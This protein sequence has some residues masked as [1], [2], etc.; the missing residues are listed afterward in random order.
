MLVFVDDDR[1]PYNAVRAWWNDGSKGMKYRLPREH[2]FEQ[3]GLAK[4]AA[5]G[6]YKVGEG[7]LIYDASSPAA[8]TH[9]RDGADHLRSLVR[10]ACDAVKLDYRETNYLALRRGP[11]LIAAGLGESLE[12]APH[13]LHGHF[14]DLFDAKLPIVESVT[15]T[16]GTRHFLFD[17]DHSRSTKPAVLASACKVLGARPLPTA[18][19]ASSPKGP[20]RSRPSS[21]SRCRRH[22]PRC[23]WTTGRCLARRGRGTPRARPF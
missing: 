12:A 13:T 5:P 20:R 1:D 10:R 8:L 22:R 2:L 17:L 16:P 11:Y 23:G 7:W 6:S 18:R 4:D 9:R 3:L 19:S 14:I 21:G 15:L